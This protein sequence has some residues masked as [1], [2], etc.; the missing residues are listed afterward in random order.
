MSQPEVSTRSGELQTAYRYFYPEEARSFVPNVVDFFSVLRAYD[1]VSRSTAG[2]A[3]R[4][5]G[6]FKEIELLAELRL[7]VVR[8]LCDRLREIQIPPAGWAAIEQMLAPGNV[9]ITS[10]WDM[11]VEWYSH[12]RGIRLRLGSLPEDSALTL[13]K[14]HGSVD[15]TE[16]R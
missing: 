13:I 4:F 8:I 12:C 2:G 7:A 6:G 1:D 15:W 10:N 5:P 9:V 3:Q 14:L 16:Q 11:F